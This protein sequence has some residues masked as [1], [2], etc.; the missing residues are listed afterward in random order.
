MLGISVIN[1]TSLSKNISNYYMH[2]LIITDFCVN[3][4]KVE[5]AIISEENTYNCSAYNELE[6]LSSWDSVWGAEHLKC[7]KIRDF[8][9][10][11]RVRS[12]LSFMYL[13]LARK[14][15]PGGSKSKESTCNLENWVQSPG[16]ED[17][18][19]FCHSVMSNSLLPHR[20]AHQASL[21]II[22]SWSVLRPLSIE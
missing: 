14:G 7:F 21:S 16:W 19:E 9:D 17:P 3:M 10:I 20:Q 2:E 12:T 22:N 18:L 1:S 6:M 5:L 8:G 15:F 13:S 11:G 4:R